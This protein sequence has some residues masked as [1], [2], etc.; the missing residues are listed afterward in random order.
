MRRQSAEAI[1]DIL[2]Q[3]LRQEGIETPLN[4]YRLVQAWSEV[5][6]EGIQHYTDDI[7]IRNRVLFVKLKSA[8]LRA[9]L[10]YNR[11]TLVHRLNSHVGAQVIEKIVFT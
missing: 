3:M 6:G 4:E 5:M 9:E 11:Q 1:G 10:M 7:F 2:H 8:A